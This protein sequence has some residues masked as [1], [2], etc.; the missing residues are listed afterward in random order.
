MISRIDELKPEQVRSRRR[1]SLKKFPGQT[2]RADV[3]RTGEGFDVYC[4]F[5]EQSGEFGRRVMWI[6]IT[7]SMPRRRS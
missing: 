2:D 5:L 4:E 7:T 3:G 6:S 1:C